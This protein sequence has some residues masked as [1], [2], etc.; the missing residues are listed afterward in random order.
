MVLAV[1][2]AAAAAAESV[3]S[4]GARVTAAVAGAA[5][6]DGLTMA[7]GWMG[8]DPAPLRNVCGMDQSN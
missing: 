5:G 7:D 3:S 6:K 2:V 4:G 1:V 8:S